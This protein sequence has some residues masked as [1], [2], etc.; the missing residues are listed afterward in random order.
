M[1][2]RYITGAQAKVQSEFL[3]LETGVIPLKQIISS[4][5]LM[6]LKNIL[7]KTPDEL[8]R[9][10]YEEQKVQP[11]KG[12]WSELVKSDIE[13]FVLNMDENA[14]ANISI[15]EYKRIVKAKIK[16][17]VFSQLRFKQEGHSKIRK[18]VYSDLK[19]QG[20]LKSHMINKNQVEPG[21]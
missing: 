8:V 11:V 9:R 14:I 5:R 7:N 12:D 10:V 6:Y 21:I 15:S 18:I 1:L 2:L 16:E 3:Y 19:T 13:E 4:R 20:Y 17:N